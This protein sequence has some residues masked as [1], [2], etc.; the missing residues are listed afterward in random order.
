MRRA[1][2]AKRGKNADSA[3]RDGKENGALNALA[4]WPAIGQQEGEQIFVF[5]S[6]MTRDWL[7]SGFPLIR[8]TEFFFFFYY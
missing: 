7:V 6:M 8:K 3:V 2:V 5:K 1:V 4:G